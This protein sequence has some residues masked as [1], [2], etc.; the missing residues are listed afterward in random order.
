MKVVHLVEVNNI[1]FSHHHLRL[2]ATLSAKYY[3]NPKYRVCTDI[4][5][6]EMTRTPSKNVSER[7]SGIKAS[8]LTRMENG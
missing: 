6:P 1:F 8:R 5:S 7:L 3:R 4:A 2:Y